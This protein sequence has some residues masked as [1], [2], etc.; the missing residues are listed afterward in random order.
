MKTITN[1]LATA[2]AL[3]F[4]TTTTATAASQL[5][6]MTV[7][8]SRIEMPL[9]EVGASLSV[10]SGS[11]IEARGEISLS[12]VLRSM[13]SVNVSNN[14]GMGKQT[15]LR[16]RGEEGYRTKVFFNGMDISDPSGTQI[17]PQIQHIMAANIDRVE[18]LRGPQGMMYGADSGGVINIISKKGDKPIE[19]DVSA[20]YG[21]YNTRQLSGNL[22]GKQDRFDYSLIASDLSTDGFNAT[23]AD[24][25]PADD[26]GYD[27][28]TL[29]FSGGFDVTDSLRI[30]GTIL[31]IDGDSQFDHCGYPY[32]NVCNGSFDQTNYKTD[33]IYNIGASR[34]QLSYSVRDTKRK[35]IADHSVR[36]L[37]TKGKLKTVQYLGSYTFSDAIK[38]LYGSD[39]SNAS[40]DNAQDDTDRN[41][42]GIYTE[43]QS[44]IAQQIYFTAGIRHDDNDDFGEHTS[45][46]TTLAYLLD[47]DRDNTVKLRSSWG[48]GFRA[49]SLYEIAYNTGPYAYPPASLVKL[50]EEKSRGYD[51]GAEYYHS[52]GLSVSLTYFDQTIDDAIDFDLA[53]FSGYLQDVGTSKSKGAELAFELPLWRALS[54]YGNYTYNDA[55]DADGQ[56]R[57]RRPRNILNLGIE[58]RAIDDRLHVNVDARSVNDVVDEQYGMG[59]SDLDNYHT[60][61]LGISYD[62]SE[63]VEVYLRGENIFDEKYQE[64]IGF[65]T[66]GAS[67]YGGVRLHF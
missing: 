22:R 1:T 49:P 44:N 58:I 14:G 2:G 4:V 61:N 67:T 48:T 15:T 27:N 10:I 17:Q 32:S 36:T 52:N 59:Y 46:R 40:M 35:N 63:T 62:I 33:L 66:A 38:L 9:R 41:E 45:Y 7:T 18:I 29:G 31:D 47:I 54:V 5:E 65:N 57:K 19:G 11:E 20:E 21:R 50:K 64:V 8:A 13:P 23:T 12:D 30:Q 60:V 3:L 42:K 6:E 24:T 53:G 39:W 26:D 34:N 28:T 51:I 43:F 16:I 37:D 25:S 55:R 56:Q